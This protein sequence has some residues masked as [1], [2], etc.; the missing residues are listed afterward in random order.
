MS[1][2]VGALR[3]LRGDSRQFVGTLVGRT[4][5]QHICSI[6][7]VGSA[8]VY[9]Y[10]NV[11]SGARTPKCVYLLCD[12]CVCVC[13][14]VYLLLRYAN[15][16]TPSPD[17]CRVLAQRRPLRSPPPRISLPPARTR[18]VLSRAL[19][20]VH[21]A[22]LRAKR[23][24]ICKKRDDS[25]DFPPFRHRRDRTRENNKYRIIFR[26]TMGH[27]R[28]RLCHY[29]IFFFMSTITPYIFRRNRRPSAVAVAGRVRTNDFPGA[30]A[31]CATRKNN[32]LEHDIFVFG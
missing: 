17:R 32:A 2:Y 6:S 10:T 11:A 22:Y 16:T 9:L 26:S 20:R 18:I 21:A 19:V 24:K 4:V 23:L 3:R 28:S 30:V 7:V 29:F 8:R 13:V 15:L 1:C 12:V 25:R 31:L 14:C 5:I 27:Y